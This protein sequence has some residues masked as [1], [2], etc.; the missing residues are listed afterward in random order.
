MKSGY[1]AK[2]LQPSPAYFP[3]QQE[4]EDATTHNQPKESSQRCHTQRCLRDSI[5][6][7]ATSIPWIIIILLLLLHAAATNVH[8]V[9]ST[10]SL[11]NLDHHIEPSVNITSGHYYID[12]GASVKDATEAGCTFSTFMNG[13]FPP[14]CTD[15]KWEDEFRADGS[16]HAYR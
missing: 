10:T 16:Y 14:A 1:Q 3:V 11:D 9:S 15:P 7:I 4:D 12:C 13:W 6:I 8:T 2:A 5:I